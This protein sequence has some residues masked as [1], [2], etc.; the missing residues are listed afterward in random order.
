VRGEYLRV[1]FGS[2]STTTSTN[3]VAFT[4]RIAFPTNV[5]T[6]SVGDL[7]ANVFRAGFNFYF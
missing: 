1:S 2:S 4:P 7:S 6:H 5:F 3:L